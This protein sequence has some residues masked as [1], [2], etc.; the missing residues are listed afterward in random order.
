MSLKPIPW[1]KHNSD[2]KVRFQTQGK[3]KGNL[4]PL[5]KKPSPRPEMVSPLTTRWTFLLILSQPSGRLVNHADLDTATA[6]GRCGRKLPL[7]MPCRIFPLYEHTVGLYLSV[8]LWLGRGMRLF[9]GNRIWMEALMR[10]QLG[11]L[12]G[13][14]QHLLRAPAF[15]PS[16]QNLGSS[17]CQKS[18]FSVRSRVFWT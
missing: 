5:V 14:C 8:H 13:Q 4:K 12:N 17:S 1:A 11:V 15:L 16:D 18:G 9:L 7:W 10:L 2:R 3:G 6:A